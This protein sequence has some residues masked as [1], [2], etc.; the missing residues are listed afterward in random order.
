MQRLDPEIFNIMKTNLKHPYTGPKGSEMGA[1]FIRHGIQDATALIKSENPNEKYTKVLEC[2]DHIEKKKEYYISLLQK[3][4]N[5]DLTVVIHGDL[6]VN[7]IL[8]SL[9]RNTNKPNLVKFVDFQATRIGSIATDLLHF[10]Y[11]SI[12]PNTRKKFFDVL[13]KFYH[14]NLVGYLESF[15]GSEDKDYVKAITF[16]RITDEIT[17]Y[18]MYG[19]INAILV[20]P[21][22]V[23]DPKAMSVPNADLRNGNSKSLI[24]RERLLD[25]A[26]EYISK[27]WI[28]ED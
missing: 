14:D 23:C 11:T 28:G 12:E 2:L 17:K 9:D 19:L 16:S 6:W 10:I 22:V 4:S 5:S 27:G 3:P 24:F 25:V 8:F 13:L 21:V 26:E 15:L 7:N 20:L 1:F 18:R